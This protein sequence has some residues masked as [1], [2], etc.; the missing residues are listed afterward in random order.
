MQPLP[1][2]R[3]AGHHGL[4][5]PD[6]LLGLWAGNQH[7][8]A[9]LYAEAAEMGVADDIL[10][11]AEALQIL[12]GP[13]ELEQVG[14]VDGVVAVKQQVRPVPPHESL[15]QDEEERADFTVGVLVGK[16]R[17]EIPLDVPHTVGGD[18]HVGGVRHSPALYGWPSTPSGK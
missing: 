12:G 13:M 9:H 3:S 6:H 2:Q 14:L 18:A 17:V 16:L 7:P 4:D 11:G 10:Y 8:L 1:V 5:A 15:E